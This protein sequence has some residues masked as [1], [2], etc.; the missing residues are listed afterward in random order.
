[1]LLRLHFSVRPVA[2]IVCFRLAMAMASAQ[3]APTTPVAPET[4]SGVPSIGVVVDKTG[5]HTM[6]TIY[7]KPLIGQ[8]EQKLAEPILDRVINNDLMLSGWFQPPAHIEWARENDRADLA[9]GKIQFAN[10]ARM[11]V[12]YVVQAEYSVSGNALSA[13]VRVYDTSMAQYIYGNRYQQYTIGQVRQ[14]GHAIAND[15]I[16]KITG[17][18]GVADTEILF[19]AQGPATGGS[20]QIAIMDA[21]GYNVRMLTPQGELTA[22]PC[23]GANATEI[24]Y[25]TYKDYNPDL[26]GMRLK[27]R[28]AWRLSGQ[29]GLNIS[30]AWSAAAQ[31]IALVLTRDGNS[32]IYAIDCRGGGRDRLTVNRAIDSSPAW[33]PDGTQIAFTSDRTGGPQLYIMDV[34]TRE[35]RQLTFD[36]S[37]NDGAAWS[38]DGKW[39]AFHSR[40]DGFHICLIKPDGSDMRVLTG[41][42][43][44]T[45]AP[46]S[47]MIA[48]T[49]KRN[50]APQIYSMYPDGT[51][52]H[53]LTNLTYGAQSAA[54]SPARTK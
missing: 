29:A 16:E 34:R 1:M 40:R 48:F 12:P 45:W 47:R 20:K 30:P 24:Y 9:A 4:P 42:E 36:G 10:W 43:D 38:P 13:D 53:Q 37:Y 2:A 14:L 11:D 33:S 46:N 32:E 27:D 25:T 28:Y 51:S 23:W 26:Y 21:D 8:S 52:I 41:G 3:T 31:K 49:S 6:T 19:V 17:V 15:I 39:I 35:Q 7:V 22:T 50:G 54:W 5:K 44:P 18:K